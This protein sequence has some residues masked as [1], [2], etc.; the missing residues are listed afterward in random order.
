MVDPEE[1]ALEAGLR[2]VTDEEPGYYRLRKGK[3]FS[4]VDENK[5][6]VQCQ[7]TLQ[8][9][10]DLVIPPAWK[11]VWVC[12][13]QNGHLQV[14]GRD[15]K[16]R[17]QYRYHPK[18][19][20]HRNSTKF[21]R[22]SHLAKK[23][24]L[25]KKQ[26]QIDLKRPGLPREKVV[27]AIIK[28]M[29]ITQ[30]RVGNSA[31]A[32]ENETYGLT[33]ILNEHAE[34]HGQKVHMAF[35]GK[36]GVDHDMA[37]SDPVISKIIRRCQDLPGE[38]LFAYESDEGQVVDINSTHVNDYLKEVTGEDFTAKD[39]RT[40]GGTCK[41]IES[42]IQ[43]MSLEN[44]S[45]TAWKKRQLEVIRETASHLHNTVTVC[46]KYY[47]HPAVF[48]HYRNGNLQLLV[49]K[50]RTSPSMTRVEKILYLLL[51]KL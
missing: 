51:Q 8:R 50:S 14:T 5:I 33:T 30:S 15:A 1:S 35:R 32:E 3:G 25:L 42:L 10:K 45:E 24:P 4:F 11:E 46:R 27:A 31:Y 17:K 38:E 43:N 23:L 13:I 41:A 47:I 22:M 19:N 28:I 29:L 44:L 2:Y 9:I 18:W 49:K 12:K 21:D 37:F 26:L 36:S 7:K 40:W 39:L 34:V 6:K 20:E 16:K 48:E